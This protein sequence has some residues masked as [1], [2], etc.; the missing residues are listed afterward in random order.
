VPKDRVESLTSN[1]AELLSSLG[2]QL[3]QLDARVAGAE[4]YGAPRLS[5]FRL[6][7]PS[8]FDLKR[9]ILSTTAY[10]GSPLNTQHFRA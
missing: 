1:L 10:N 4:L 8:K 9:R 7:G 5:T 6:L 2:N 3:P